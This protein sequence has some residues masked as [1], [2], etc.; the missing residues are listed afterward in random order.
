MMTELFVSGL[1]AMIVFV[2]LITVFCSKGKDVLT[3]M[4][5]T[6]IVLSMSAVAGFG[7][8]T[9]QKYEN[10]LNNVTN[11]V[12]PQVELYTQEELDNLPYKE[13]SWV[14]DNC[15]IQTSDGKIVYVKDKRD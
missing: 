7:M 11:V 2:I 12:L 6:L 8:V 10:L 9:E 4:V 13:Y 5:F 3:L 14:I 1:I 15:S